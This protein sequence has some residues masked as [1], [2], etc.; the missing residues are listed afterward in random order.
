MPTQSLYLPVFRKKYQK[1]AKSMSEDKS[2]LKI[3]MV[4]YPFHPTSP[5]STF[6][7]EYKYRVLALRIF[8]YKYWW[9]TVST[10]ITSS[11]KSTEYI[12]RS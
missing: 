6:E 9:L 7:Y 2:L 8:E 12:F 1:A 3:N 4:N 10:S 11:S 5:Y